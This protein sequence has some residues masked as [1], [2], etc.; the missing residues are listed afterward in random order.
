MRHPARATSTRSAAPASAPELVVQLTRRADG[1]SVLRCTRRDGSATW[2]RHEGHRATF[3]PFHDLLHLA[4]EST[5]GF[6][7]GFYG[8]I[9]DGWDIAETDG[10]GARGRV[11]G[12][13]VLVEHLVGMLGMER[14]GGAA[15]LTAAEVAERLAPLAADGTVERIPAIDD[16]RLDAVRRRTDELHRA[17][18]ALADG[19]TLEVP[20]D[21]APE[22]AM[23]RAPR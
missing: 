12:E 10:K 4:V 20:F 15:P 14:V 2:Q 21:R 16:A 6:R 1:G 11:P 18:A 19:E 8:L 17:Y 3:F 13:A 23:E 7:R 22:G 5:L 9:A